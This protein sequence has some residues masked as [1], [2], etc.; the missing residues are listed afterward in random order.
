MAVLK[1][2]LDLTT[3][4]LA[5]LTSPDALA[6]FLSR[7][8]YDTSRRTVLTPSS[9][10]LSGDTATSIRSIELLSEDED[11]FLRVLFVQP[12]SLTAKVRNDLI[13]IIGKSNVDYLVV[14]AATFDTLEFVLLDKKTKEQAGPGGGYKVQVVPKI[15]SI[16]RRKPRSLSEK[17]VPNLPS[18]PGVSGPREIGSAAVPKPGSPPFS[19]G[20]PTDGVPEDLSAMESPNLRASD[21]DPGPSSSR[22][23]LGLVLDRTGPP[24]RPDPLLRLLRTGDPRRPALRCRHDGHLVDL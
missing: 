16:D 15:F 17:G 13:R 21:P 7:L 9:L 22:G 5:G 11:G 23:R 1:T 18:H 19:L 20:G 24:T 12:K 6:A 14:L 8:G 3:R 10:G 4:D 2:D